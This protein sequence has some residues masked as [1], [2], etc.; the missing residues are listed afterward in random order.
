LPASQYGTTVETSNR[1]RWQVTFKFVYM[2]DY[3][4][5]FP[6]VEPNL[7]SWDEAYLVMVD[8]F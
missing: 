4:D 2:M 1:K 8:N 6:Y 5:R 3:I 7:H